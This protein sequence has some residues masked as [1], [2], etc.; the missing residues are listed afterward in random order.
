MTLMKA[1][2]DGQVPMTEQ[3]EAEIKAVWAKEKP[4][5]E[6]KKSLEQR[7]TELEILVK[8]LTKT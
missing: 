4:S 3:E 7:V 6:P 5:I 2:K 8:A 1:T